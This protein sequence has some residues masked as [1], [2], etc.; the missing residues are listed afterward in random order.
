MKIP[1]S[2]MVSIPYNSITNMAPNMAPNMAEEGTSLYEGIQPLNPIDP[3]GSTGH[4]WESKPGYSVRSS[5][6]QTIIKRGNVG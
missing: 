6:T 3:I 4:A 1:L 2:S 5:R